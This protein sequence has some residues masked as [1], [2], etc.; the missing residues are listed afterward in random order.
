MS[1]QS[2]WSR[3][4][5]LRPVRDTDDQGLHIHTVGS[6]LSHAPLSSFNH[7]KPDSM[8]QGH[9]SRRRSRR[10]Q[11]THCMHSKSCLTLM[12]GVARKGRQT[13]PRLSPLPHST[14]DH[15]SFSRN[16][17]TA[18]AS[19][20]Q[21]LLSIQ[22]RLERRRPNPPQ[23]GADTAGA[24]AM[25]DSHRRSPPRS[26]WRDDSYKYRGITS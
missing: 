25:A 20:Q 24:P 19:L 22:K 17:C 5:S 7:L 9:S 6:E 14:G 16:I 23:S 1:E 21:R 12:Y 8:A 18:T 13:S 26:H 15:P 4:W 11:S 3:Q 2:T 10:A